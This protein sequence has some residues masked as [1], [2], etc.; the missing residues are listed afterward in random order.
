MVGQPSLGL[1]LLVTYFNSVLYLDRF[2]AGS[3]TINHVEC[4]DINTN[5]WLE[6]APMCLNRSALSACVISSLKNARDYSL[7]GRTMI[8]WESP[9]PSDNSLGTDISPGATNTLEA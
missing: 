4:Y 5:E 1:V 6:A 8:K 2:V 9:I 3:T 7:H